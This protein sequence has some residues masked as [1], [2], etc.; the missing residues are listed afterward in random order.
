MCHCPKGTLEPQQT[1]FDQGNLV[2]SILIFW[3]FASTVV[4]EPMHFSFGRTNYIVAEGE[5]TDDTANRLDQFVHT[6]PVGSEWR[7]LLWLNSPGGMVL[8]SLK[9]GE[10]I[11]ELGLET[12]VGGL[13]DSSG[14]LIA[15]SKCASACVYAFAGGTK[16][17]LDPSGGEIAVHQ[18]FGGN[19]SSAQYLMTLTGMYLDRVRV[20]R[21]LL[22]YMAVVPPDEI[23]KLPVDIAQQMR[24]VTGLVI[25]PT[26]GGPQFRSYPD[27]APPQL[28]ASPTPSDETAKPPMSQTDLY[29]AANGD[30]NSGKFD[31][32]LH[33]F[34]DFLK[35]YFNADLA[36]N[37]QYWIGQIYYSQKKY[38]D[39]AQAFDLV[40]EKYPDNAKT[41]D[42]KLYKGMCLVALGRR[43][44]AH[45]IF[46]DM[47]KQYPNT[48]AYTRACNE[49]RLLGMVCY[50]NRR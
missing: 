7:R 41:R 6:I 17:L 49:D 37:A 8:S 25:A 38:D 28:V 20:D 19:E 18:F 46:Q 31:L 36:P 50:I 10:K 44:Q 23:S 32:A 12:Y 22:D 15:R 27:A 9:L 30:Y 33:E 39:A 21:R 11:R 35:Y 14:Q 1:G 3:V 24:L 43:S 47:E 26:R 48:D 40:L 16:R 34:Q 29:N 42:A 5:I 4:A 2:K 13:Y 45:G